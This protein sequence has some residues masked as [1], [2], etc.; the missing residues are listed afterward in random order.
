MEWWTGA[1][2]T[3]G[4]SLMTA[5]GGYK[6]RSLD[7]GGAVAGG[8]VGMITGMGGI[9][10][11][12]TLFAF[13]FSSSLLTRLG[14]SRKK[15]VEDGYRKGGRRTWVQVFSNGAVGC[16]FSFCLFL[17]SSSLFS[18]DRLLSVSSL[19]PPLDS[20]EA[21][22]GWGW[23][24]PAFWIGGMVGHYACCNGDTWASEMGVGFGSSNPLLLVGFGDP[25]SLF[26]LSPSSAKKEGTEG[27]KKE[28]KKKM[29]FLLRVPAG[30][31]GGMSL[32]GTLSSIAGGLFV[33]FGFLLPCLCLSLLPPP[34]HFVRSFFSFEADCLSASLWILPLSA[35]AGF[36]GSLVCPLSFLSL[37][38][39]SLLIL[40]LS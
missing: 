8:I 3:T 26:L 6:A 36:L 22:G 4:L 12:S 39:V 10:S 18:A 15:R 29:M 23:S 27:G 33:G 1:V 32:I 24:W 20:A 17:S 37:D 5:V 31:N 9:S 34:L 25:S 28:G 13:F 19:F 40:S 11:L 38:P 30:T 7:R 14:S 21:G 2:L 16:F 35:F